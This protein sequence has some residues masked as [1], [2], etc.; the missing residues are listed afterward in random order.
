MGR[1]TRGVR[2]EPVGRGD[3]HADIPLEGPCKYAAMQNPPGAGSLNEGEATMGHCP[4]HMVPGERGP[5]SPSGVRTSVQS[6]RRARGGRSARPQAV[7]GRLCVQRRMGGVSAGVEETG[8]RVWRHRLRCDAVCV[9]ERGGGGQAAH[10]RELTLFRRP[11]SCERRGS[12]VPVILPDGRP[13]GQVGRVP[14][15]CLPGPGVPPPLSCDGGGEGEDGGIAHHPG[16][17]VKGPRMP[18]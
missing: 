9:W 3:R 18:C 8:R 14:R 17:R 5:P 13:D 7:P 10:L 11:M 12:R 2:A 1:P 15:L 4:P 16:P 6:V